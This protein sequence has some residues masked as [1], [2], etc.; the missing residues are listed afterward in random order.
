MTDTARTE[1]HENRLKRLGIRSWRRGTKEMDLILGPFADGCLAE[2]EI[3]ALDAY[4][5]LLAENDHDLYGWVSG[6][7]AA[8]ARHG[9]IIERIRAFHGLG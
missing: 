2:L 7:A 6:V 9:G 8:P 4:D 5:A 1:T 3:A